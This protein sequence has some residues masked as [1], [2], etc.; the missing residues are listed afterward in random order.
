MFVTTKI[1][2]SNGFSKTSSIS[3]RE[4]VPLFFGKCFFTPDINFSKFLNIDITDSG[5]LV[6]KSYSICKMKRISLTNLNLLRN[7]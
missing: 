2:V 5:Y 3:L 4:L 7:V 6:A 1:P